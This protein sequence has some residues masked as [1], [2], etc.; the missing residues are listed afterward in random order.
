MDQIARAKGI[1]PL[2]F[3][4][5]LLEHS[6][7]GRDVLEA[8]SEMAGWHRR[9]PDEPLGIAYA[10]LDGTLFATLAEIAADPKSGHIQVI[11]V[12][13]AVDAGIPVQ[14]N[15]IAGQFEGA[16]IF[17]LSNVLKEQ[18]T[19]KDGAVQ[20]SN[21]HDYP[22][23]RMQESPQIYTRVIRSTRNPTGIGDTVGVTIAPAVA[24]AY[25]ALT[26]RQLTALPFKTAQRT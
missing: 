5:G 17:A 25:A 15:N 9:A 10:E 19:V 26:G 4:L 12:W 6:P 3:R 11:R 18:I 23:L 1:D 14:P 8:A 2:E 16:I 24:N 22:L 7:A 20:Q 21:F 13:A